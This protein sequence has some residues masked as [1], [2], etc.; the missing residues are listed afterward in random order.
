MGHYLCQ[1]LNVDLVFGLDAVFSIQP[2]LYQRAI[3]V[4]NLVNN[5]ICIVRVGCRK[6][7]D[8]VFLLHL[9]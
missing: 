3:W 4:N 1:V 5:R 8:M 6:H 7:T 2:K 9:L